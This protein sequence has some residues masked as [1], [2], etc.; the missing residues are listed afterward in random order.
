MRV[1][2]VGLGGVGGYIC[3]YLAKTQHKLVGF[4]RG[5]H[6][7]VIQTQGIKILEDALSWSVQFDA[8]T[9]EEADGIFDCVLFCVK[10]YD[11]ETSYAKI[12]PFINE[13]TILLSFANGVSNGDVLR[14]I[15]QSVVLDG[16]VYILSHQEKAGVIRKKGKVFA[17]VFGGDTEAMIRVKE[18]FD[19]AGLRN[20]T[21]LDIK[22]EIWKKYIFISAF[23]T[24]TTYYD[25]SIRR[26]YETHPEVCEKLLKEIAEV[27]AVQG[28]DIF[29]E[30]TKAM[31]TASAL[32]K[33]AST[34]MHL[35]F[36][37]NKRDELE[38]LSGYIVQESQKRGVSIPLMQEMYKTLFPRH[39]S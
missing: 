13:K 4:A 37:N 31:E 20:K 8:R 35:D 2:V 1:A 6:L 24:L 15:S 5:T 30:V 39:R 29:D 12:A 16:C 23:A 38:S 19:A 14:K 25:M 9:L 32:P 21:P 3:A 11:L 27:A 18:L 28:I 22:K 36:Q 26:V 7:D 17:A 33:D 34:S 10:S